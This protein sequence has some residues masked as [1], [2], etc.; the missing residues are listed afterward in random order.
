MKNIN[1]D[2]F[3][4]AQEMDFELALKE[5]KSGKKKVTG[6]GIYFPK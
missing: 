3:I 4:K 2:R 1:L 5:I 6:C